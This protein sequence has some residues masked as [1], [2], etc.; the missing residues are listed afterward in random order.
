MDTDWC[1]TCNKRVEGSDLYCSLQCQSGAGPS[2]PNRHLHASNPEDELASCEDNLEEGEGF[3]E[4]YLEDVYD[5]D[6]L[7]QMYNIEAVSKTSWAGRRGSAGIRAWAAEIPLGAHPDVQD[8]SPP[9]SDDSSSVTSLSSTSSTYRAPNLVRPSRPLP[10]SLTMTKPESSTTTPPRPI[11][12]LQK[13]ITALTNSPDSTA[14]TSVASEDS[15]PTPASTHAMPFSALPGRP[16]PSI[17]NARACDIAACTQLTSP[18]PP[19][20]TSALSKD[21]ESCVRS[22]GVPIAPRILSSPQS[23]LDYFDLSPPL[24]VTG[25]MVPHPKSRTNTRKESLLPEPV[26]GRRFRRVAA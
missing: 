22:R 4:D 26:R 14:R 13:H 15:L 17:S 6:E 20:R 5:I 7:G 3:E 19:P 16:F 23:S 9:P 2:N 25:S 8:S 12:N 10:P 24:W 18:L 11:L 21:E 1:L